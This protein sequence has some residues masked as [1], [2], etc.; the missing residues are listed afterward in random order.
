MG[1]ANHAPITAPTPFACGNNQALLA[2]AIALTAIGYD[3]SAS[4]R[5]R[6]TAYLVT[7]YRMRDQSDLDYET[8]ALLPAESGDTA[9]VPA[10]QASLSA[11][12]AMQAGSTCYGRAP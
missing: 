1:G 9:E 7:R 4:V 12:R 3:G 2:D 5:Q 10:R 11:M 6:V 8:L